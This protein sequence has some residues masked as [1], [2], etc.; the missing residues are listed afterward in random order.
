[1][2]PTTAVDLVKQH[3]FQR[4]LVAS[5]IKELKS[6]AESALSGNEA[7]KS[8]FKIRYKSLD[9]NYKNFE[10]SHLLVL[11]N[12]SSDDYDEEDEIRKEIDDVYYFI[13]LAYSQLFDAETGK[14]QSRASSP[15][16]SNLSDVSLNKETGKEQSRASS[17]R[18]SR[19]QLPKLSLPNW[20][21]DLKSYESFVDIFTS[22]IHT[23]EDLN[24][25]DKFQYLLLS[26]TD[27]PLNLLKSI[28]L[29]SE[30]YNLAFET[31]TNR[32]SNPRLQASIHYSAIKN[33]PPLRSDQSSELRKL[34][35]CFSENISILTK[36]GLP[37]EHWDFV[38][39][40]LLLEKIDSSTRRRFELHS[41]SNQIPS[42]AE[43]KDFLLKQ[44]TA[45]D[46]INISKPT[47]VVK[48]YEKKPFVHRFNNPKVTLVSNESGGSRSCPL[49]KNAHFLFRCPSFLSKTP[50]DR[51][52]FAKQNSLCIKCLRPN[53]RVQRCKASFCQVCR[54]N[55]HSLLHR[56]QNN[57]RPVS[58]SSAAN[59]QQITPGLTSTSDDSGL[60]SCPV[61]SASKVLLGTA[62][63][64]LCD[65]SGNFRTVRC[66]L[67]TA[68]QSSI[69]S[70]NCIRRFGL[71]PFRSSPSIFG[72]GQSHSQSSGSVK[73]SIRPR[74]RS[75]L[76][77]NLDAIVLQP[78][79]AS[80]P[81][82]VIRDSPKWEY[83][84]N[85]NLADPDFM[86]T[87]EIDLLI[88]AE[89]YPYILMDGSIIPKNKN[90]PAAI[91]TQFGFVVSGRVS[92]GPEYEQNLHSFCVSVNLEDTVKQ[93]WESE[94][95]PDR[96]HTSPDDA[97]CERIFSENVYRKVT[98]R[99]VVPLP[100]KDFEPFGNSYQMA[101]N[102]LLSLER[103]LNLE[104]HRNN[105]TAYN[106]FMRDY[107][108]QG[109]MKLVEFDSPKPTLV[110]YIPHT[111]IVK[112]DSQTTKLRVVFDASM[113]TDRGISLN[114][115]QFVGPKLQ[116]DICEILLH[117]REH[118]IVFTADVKQ[119]FRNIDID[120]KYHDIQ[121]ILWRFSDK[122]HIREYQLTTV[123]YGLASSP[124][125]AIRT[126]HQLAHDEGANYPRASKVLMTDTFVDDIITGTSNVGDALLLQKELISLLKAGQF[127]LRKWSSNSPELLKSIDRVDRALS[128][129]T[130]EPQFLKILGLQWSPSTDVFF[131]QVN[132]TSAECTKRSILSDI[133]RIFD[134]LGFISPVTLLAKRFIQKLWLIG[135]DWDSIPPQDIVNLW[136]RFKS[137][138]PLLSDFLVKRYIPLDH[139]GDSISFQIHGFSDASSHG[140]ASVVYLRISL[141]DNS[142]SVHLLCSKTKVAPLKQTSIPRLELMAAQILS[143]LIKYV[144][145]TYKVIC[146]FES[147]NAW[148]DSTVALTWIRSSPHLYKPFVSN[149]IAA[150]QENI[151]PSV[152]HYI[153][154]EDNPADA[155]SRGQFP[156][157]FLQNSLWLNG[158]TWLTRDRSEWPNF[159]SPNSTEASV[160]EEK[161][162]ITLVASQEVDFLNSLL[163]RFSSLQNIIRI[164]AYVLR[165]IDCIKQKGKPRGFFTS[166]ELHRSLM[167]MVKIVQSFEFEKEI[168]NLKDGKSCSKQYRKLNPFVCPGGFLRVGGRLSNS[169]LDFNEKHPA[170]L[171]KGHR[172]TELIIEDTHRKYLHPGLNTLRYLIQQNFWIL[173]PKKAINSCLS[174]CV[175]CFRVKPRSIQP[176]MGDLPSFRVNK[177]LK[178]FLSVG[179]DYGGPLF[180]KCAKHRSRVILKSYVCVFVC[181]ATKAV[182]I[183]L[184]SDLTAD[185]FLA[186]LRRFIARRGTCHE[187]ISD[188][189]TNF[190]AANRML[191]QYLQQAAESQSIV[192]KFNPPSSPHMG[193][194]FEA[195]IKSVKNHLKRVIGQQVLTFEELYTV[196]TQVEALLNSR[197][198][199]PVSNDPNDLLP[200]TPG[201]FLTLH[202]LSS[203]PDPDLSDL[204]INRL[205]R[206]QLVQRI[207]QDLWKRFSHEYL[208]TLQQR[209]KWHNKASI[210][211]LPGTLVLVKDNNLPPLKWLM[212]RIVETHPGTDGVVRVA[213][214]RTA[215]GI[216]KRPL[217]KLCPLPACD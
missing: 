72:I 175:R 145:E 151:A 187:I 3:M 134:P 81:N 215:S 79:C 35:D 159:I 157:A 55:H 34:V 45:L 24:D 118:S 8:S 146:T 85:L 129:D 82:F 78:I 169:E 111:F 80:M 17:P 186:A 131:Y 199:G 212:G 13:L 92:V 25:I 135:H 98:G 103:R 144:L 90:I 149:R 177:Q 211:I 9:E 76:I 104:H 91:N 70:K 190:V 137:E 205:S 208:H 115:K 40:D 200:L 127:H 99:Y 120:S 148:C 15:S 196:L 50:L 94:M 207:V 61:Q 143:D 28:P 108:D 217:V 101:K 18:K 150:I 165:F 166:D 2:A 93:F 201:H 59:S 171:P 12:T 197:P 47:S 73:L 77:Y 139:H 49:C 163:K 16:E 112:P 51:F 54:A 14:E 36:L 11:E 194:L 182:H 43:L 125:L 38:L 210:D 214:L 180:V 174:R 184:V 114:E 22:L 188:N 65:A 156:S 33:Y 41:P 189:G 152:W 178:P 31:L 67:D 62:L 168:K 64:E 185:A 119:M 206:W 126:L 121:R 56:E 132:L 19:V 60:T 68:S 153:P 27:E 7:S 198:L 192:W 179:I 167:T 102:R 122:E 52:S 123:T 176:I 44:C 69:V 183:E 23:N 100:L 147:V 141:A 29:T 105:K 140:I 109:H 136:Q 128:F 160:D 10:K 30:N 97:E 26:L 130:Q 133:A 158:P 83:L 181:N 142:T 154:S 57:L 86:V 5:R 107:L 113:R 216:L 32:Y 172:L 106:D 202:P 37:V 89:L 88:G 58:S 74:N 4:K 173:S 48:P 95:V 213:T 6:I 75:N 39:V 21:G 161:R 42:F 110:Y 116:Q 66:L 209:S 193:G 138:L 87:N 63:V 191:N 71:K 155:A 53:C 46:S 117:F 1:M 195:A 164:V 124:Y 204:N 170:I 203:P 96:V 20:N 162:I 84:K